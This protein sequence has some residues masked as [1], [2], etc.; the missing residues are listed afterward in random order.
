[1]IAATAIVLTLLTFAMPA[2][3]DARQISAYQAPNNGP[4]AP[5]YC[6]DVRDGKYSNGTPIQLCVAPSSGAA[7]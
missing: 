5:S 1:M 6:L 3:A 7:C 2:R 4:G